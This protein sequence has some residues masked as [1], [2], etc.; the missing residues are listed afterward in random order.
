MIF[1]KLRKKPTAPGNGGGGLDLGNLPEE[2][3]NVDTAGSLSEI[4]A[5]LA[6]AKTLN[7]TQLPKVYDPNC[8]CLGENDYGGF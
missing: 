5:A 3:E 1:D 6:Y 8:G 4:D 2:Q 7:Q